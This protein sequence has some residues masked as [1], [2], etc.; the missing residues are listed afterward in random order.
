MLLPDRKLLSFE[1]QPLGSLPGG[2]ERKK[3]LLLLY[4]EDAIKKR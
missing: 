1:Q 2:K 4:F 3:L